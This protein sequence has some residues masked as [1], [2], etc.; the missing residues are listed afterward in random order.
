[1]TPIKVTKGYQVVF[2]NPDDGE[3]NVVNFT[4]VD[5][6]IAITVDNYFAHTV[7]VVNSNGVC[8][9]ICKAE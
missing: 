4:L 6:E 8:V 9:F 5:G 3:S 2:T 7:E 1:M